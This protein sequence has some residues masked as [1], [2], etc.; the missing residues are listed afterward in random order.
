MTHEHPAHHDLFSRITINQLREAQRRV[1]KRASPGVDGVTGKEYADNLEA[2]LYQ[3]YFGVRLGVY[4]PSL[5]RSKEIE[6]PDGSLRA[7]RI[8]TYEDR[9]L[10]RAVLTLLEPMFERDFFPGSYGFRPKR[11][12]HDA[13]RYLEKRLTGWEDAWI[14]DADIKKFFDHVRHD[15][16]LELLRERI[17]R[18]PILGLVIDWARVGQ[19]AP[20]VG[21][22]QGGVISP[23]LANIYL[24]AALDQWF[25]RYGR[26]LDCNVRLIRYAD[27]FVVVVKARAGVGLAEI[28]SICDV[29]AARLDHHFGLILHPEKT[30]IISLAPTSKSTFDFL[31]FT[32][33]RESGGV[34]SLRTSA[35]STKKGLRNITAWLR[36]SQRE[37]VRSKGEA[38]LSRV[39]GHAD[40]FGWP[41]NGPQIEAYARD[42]ART[43][44]RELNGQ[45]APTARDYAKRIRSVGRDRAAQCQ[46][47]AG[48]ES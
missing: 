16:L 33:G 14:I 23:F 7:I 43:W 37:S 20:G 2:N 30:S 42:V 18:D 12:A 4:R 22:A 9:V 36:E 35:K 38:L 3:L 17:G 6:K 15:V 46:R 48:S 34:V 5:L 10:Q 8:P 39:N 1:R 13:L 32:V 45:A 11:S 19:A 31:G 41:G 29:I 44:L 25:L 27:D 21:V 26:G 24:D 40:Y 28:R 47:P